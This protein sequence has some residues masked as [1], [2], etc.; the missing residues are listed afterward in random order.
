MGEGIGYLGLGQVIASA[1]APGMGIMLADAV[2]MRMTFVISGVMALI[3]F[4]FMFTL[5]SSGT[6]EGVQK[7]KRIHPKD[8]IAVDVLGYTIVAGV[9]SFMNGI[10]ASYIVLYAQ[11]KG[12]ANVSLYFT[13]CAAVLFIIRPFSGKLMD[14]K[15][16]NIVVIPGIILAGISLF[17]IGRFA[18]LSLILLT[19]IIRSVG[20]GSAQPSLQAACIKKA[21][22]IRSGAAISTFLLGGDVGQGIG[23][24]VGGYFVQSSG[25]KSLFDFCGSLFI[26]AF[27]LYLIIR[28]REKNKGKGEVNY[29][30][31]Q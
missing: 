7:H 6:K 10:I 2:G 24:M 29:D 8:I 11:T 31:G 28:L 12:I 19:G 21:G 14:K 4:V 23:P 18:S 30:E 1:V 20:Q 13:V 16:L 27:I 26:G 15:G 9:F 17:L 22:K 5:P 3:T 25:Y